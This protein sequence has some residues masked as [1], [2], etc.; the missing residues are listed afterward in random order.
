MATNL[1]SVKAA[2]LTS[3]INSVVSSGVKITGLTYI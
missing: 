1:K 3:V 2:A